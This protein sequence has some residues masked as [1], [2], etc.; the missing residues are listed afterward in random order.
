MLENNNTSLKEEEISSLFTYITSLIFD[1]L[2]IPINIVDKDCKV[3]VM[4]KA[5][6]KLLNLKHEDVEGKYLPEID[7]TVRLPLVL[8]TGQAEIGQKHKFKDGRECIV[9]RIPLFYNNKIIGG[10]GIISIDDLS[11]LYN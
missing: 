7:P 10:L 3:I 6:L 1:Q 4:N 11:F 2:P 5:F 8:K 9:D